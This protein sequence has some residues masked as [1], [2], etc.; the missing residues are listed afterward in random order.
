MKSKIGRVIG[1]AV[2]VGLITTITVLQT[3]PMSDITGAFVISA[4]LS[5]A[6]AGLREIKDYYDEQNGNSRRYRRN[7]PRRS[8]VMLI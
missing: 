2:V 4:I 7:T 6:I 1:N 5:G 3:A 8:Y